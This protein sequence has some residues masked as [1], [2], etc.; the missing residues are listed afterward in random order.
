MKTI[1]RFEVLWTKIGQKQ[2]KA[3][4]LN[5]SGMTTIERLNFYG[6]SSNEKQFDGK[7][8]ALVTRIIH[9]N[10]NDVTDEVIRFT[11]QENG[12]IQQHIFNT[13]GNL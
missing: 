13:L 6:Q 1:E 2:F 4:A 11:F 7:S 10:E 5:W 3:K 8:W 9:P 12:D